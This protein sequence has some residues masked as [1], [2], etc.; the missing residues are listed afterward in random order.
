[1]CNKMPKHI[2]RL[3]IK[4]LNE[5]ISFEIVGNQ[6]FKLVA[7]L[8]IKS[9]DKILC[10]NETQGEWLCS[11][12]EIKKSKII[13]KKIEFIKTFKEHHKL[14]F[15]FCPIKPDRQKIMIEKTTELGVTNFYPVISEYSNA[16]I[17]IHKWK[18]IAISAVEQSERLDVPEF[19]EK[20][21]FATFMQNLPDVHWLSAIE[22][23]NDAISPVN[24]KPDIK[25][26]GF[27]IGPEGGFSKAEKEWLQNKTTPVFISKNV[28]RSE[29]AGIVCVAMT[30]IIRRNY[31]I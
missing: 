10:F 30:E 14:C 4:D 2:P 9:D 16:I 5:E 26:I 6:M 18:D 21:S 19:R 15:A 12:C 28:L 3:Y 17:N 31:I 11:I 7:V 29:T 27:I 23:Q 20:I 1:M 13:A 25:D 24:L 22:R 8:R